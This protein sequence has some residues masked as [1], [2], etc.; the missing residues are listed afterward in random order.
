VNI[1]RPGYAG[2]A[3]GRISFIRATLVL[4]YRVFLIVMLTQFIKQGRH[5]FGFRFIISRE[6]HFSMFGTFRGN[7]DAKFLHADIT[8]ARPISPANTML[9]LSSY[10]YRTP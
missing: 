3:Q 8:R 2:I 6:K 4:F 7:I 1:A 5:S 9:S 10:R